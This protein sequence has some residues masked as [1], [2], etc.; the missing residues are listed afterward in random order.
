MCRSCDGRLPKMRRKSKVTFGAGDTSDHFNQLGFT[1]GPIATL[2][3]SSAAPMTLHEAAA[4][5]PLPSPQPR[6]T[7][8]Q[9]AHDQAP[10]FPRSGLGR[11]TS[12]PQ[13][14]I[15]G[16]VRDLHQGTIFAVPE[17]THAHPQPSHAFP[18]HHHAMDGQASQIRPGSGRSE[19]LRGPPTLRLMPKHGQGS[20]AAGRHSWN[21][22]HSQGDAS[23]R[24]GSSGRVSLDSNEDVCADEHM[25]R[26]FQAFTRQAPG[27]KA[28]HQ[29]DGGSRRVFAPMDMHLSADSVPLGMPSRFPDQ[30]GIRLATQA[31]AGKAPSED[32]KLA[33]NQP[34]TRTHLQ[35]LA[36]GL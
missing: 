3:S 14:S 9:M 5:H 36:G 31:P 1:P 24:W 12:A 32:G 26:M 2:P 27:S 8:W 10:I 19:S 29:S 16:H 35:V 15:L 33:G 11:T 18:V 21:D 30:D 34:P 20:H 17:N 22:H 13:G 28:K 25:N 23:S 6:A 7:S 4:V